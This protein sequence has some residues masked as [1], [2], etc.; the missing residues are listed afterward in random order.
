MDAF[1]WDTSR[2]E[3]E[4]AQD[5]DFLVSTEEFAR[6]GYGIGLP[7]H[8]FWA[9]RINKEI[10]AMHESGFMTELEN[11]WIIQGEDGDWDRCPTVL[12]RSKPATLA[13]TSMLGLFLI[14]GVVIVAGIGFIT[15]EM[16]STKSKVRQQKQLDAARGAAER[17]KRLVEVRPKSTQTETEINSRRT[18]AMKVQPV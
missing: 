6:S 15:I 7:K 14:V 9:E 16:I 8:S 5:C 18:E 11:K 12:D 3:Y 10:L 17:W 13:I 1:I 2:L 4:A